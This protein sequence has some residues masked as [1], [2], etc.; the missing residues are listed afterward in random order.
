MNIKSH[1]R[2]LT[3]YSHAHVVLAF[4]ILLFAAVNGRAQCLLQRY[5]PMNNGDSTYFYNSSYG[6]VEDDFI[7]TYGGFT[8][9][10]TFSGEYTSAY[11]HYFTAGG[12][13]VSEYQLVV[14]FASRNLR[15]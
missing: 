8:I 3:V 9:E 5:W 11:L 13:L 7:S 15:G 4:L 12:I 10:Q 6:S 14:M 2:I 1:N